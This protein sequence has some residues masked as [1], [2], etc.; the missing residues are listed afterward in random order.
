MENYL[1]CGANKILLLML[2][3]SKFGAKV[4]SQDKVDDREH[5]HILL[6]F[7][8]FHHGSRLQS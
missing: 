3:L 5:L 2:L 6:T 1:G 7:L 8:K 4:N